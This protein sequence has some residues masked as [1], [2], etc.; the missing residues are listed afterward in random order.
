MIEIYTD[1]SAIDNPGPGGWAAIILYHGE[2]SIVS[3]GERRT[4]N[5]RMEI[6]AVVEGLAHVPQ[7]GERNGLL[8]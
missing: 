3:G 6:T 1:G 5:N 7:G 2:K 8:R 4:T